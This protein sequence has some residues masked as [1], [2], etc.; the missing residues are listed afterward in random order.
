MLNGA[1]GHNLLLKKREGFADMP[2]GYLQLR[3]GVLLKNNRHRSKNPS[4]F[5]GS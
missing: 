4:Y 3:S 5:A 2:D 1:L